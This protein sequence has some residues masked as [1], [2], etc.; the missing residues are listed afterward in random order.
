MEEKS[1]VDFLYSL[2]VG[3]SLIRVRSMTLS[4]DPVRQKLQGSLT[5]VASYAKKAPPKIAAPVAAPAAV[6]ATNSGLKPSSPFKTNAP[7][8]APAPTKK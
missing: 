3:G 6:R 2:G 4:P 1:L 7:T 8:K 5:L